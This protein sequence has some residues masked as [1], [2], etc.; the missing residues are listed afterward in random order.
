VLKKGIVVICLLLLSAGLFAQ[1]YLNFVENKGQWDASIK[2][3][4]EMPGG[5]IVLKNT[6]YRVLQYNADDYDQLTETLHSLKG[7]DKHADKINGNESDKSVIHGDVGAELNLRSHTYEV[8][9]LNAN[10][11]PVIVPD[12][13]QNNYNNY[14]LGNDPSKWASNCKIYQAITYK[15]V[16]PTIDIRF[17]TSNATL[18]YDV[19]VHPGGDPSK[20]ILYFDGVDGLKVKDESL[21]IKTSVGTIQEMAPYTYALNKDQRNDVACSYEVRGNFVQFKLNSAYDKS[22]TL[23]IDPSVIFISYTG[24]TA[25]NW[26]FTA[27]YD[28]AGNFYAGGVVFNDIF[29]RKLDAIER[30]ERALPSGRIGLTTAITGAVLLLGIGLGLAFYQS[31]LSGFIAGFIV[32]L[33]LLYDWKSKHNGFFGPF[34]MGM[35][36][37]FN[38]MLGML[39]KFIKCCAISMSL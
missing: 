35:C 4:S 25:D 20:V 6:G 34:N 27:T 2:F 11:N 12:K 22:S 21:Q 19:I 8:K 36:R 24:S 1:S 10:P 33:V 38:L 7:R 31:R 5:A 3:K 13:V 16:Y 17:Y 26:G 9:F 23:V 32:I 37:A 29:D 18:K 30:P 28:G 14:I 39:M 15:N